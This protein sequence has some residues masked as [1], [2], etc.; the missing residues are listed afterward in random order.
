MANSGAPDSNTDWIVGNQSG[1]FEELNPTLAA[2]VY[3]T[4]STDPLRF[5]LHPA[6][7]RAIR[8]TISLRSSK[9]DQA[10]TDAWTGDPLALAENRTLQLPSYGRYRR[11]S[12]SATINVRNQ[13]SRSTFMF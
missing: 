1:T 8:I 13:S 11:S 5:N 2:P 9:P 10:P 3:A 7:V 6:N 12:I 4:I